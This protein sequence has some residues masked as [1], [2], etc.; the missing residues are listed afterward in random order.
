M[1]NAT[2]SVFP[3]AN[4]QQV[5]GMLLRDYFAAH[6]MTAIVANLGQQNPSNTVVKERV[7]KTAYEIADAMLGAR[8]SGV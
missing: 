1:R 8:D 5:S 2:I 3:Y 6:A 4:G 7:G